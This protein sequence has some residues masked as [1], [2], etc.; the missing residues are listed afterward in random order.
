[1][2][3][4]V[5]KESNGRVQEQFFP[6]SAL[7][8]ETP[9]MAQVRGGALAFQILSPSTV[10]GVVPAANICNLG[11]A[12]RT[13]AEGTHV[14]DGPLGGYLQSEA[15][16]KGLHWMRTIW[17]SGMFQLTSG[18]HPIKS[19]DDLRGFKVRV[20]EARIVVDLFRGLGA[21]PTPMGFNEI[22]TA[23]QTKVVDGTSTPLVTI[24]TGRFYEVQKYIS[25]TNHAWSGLCLISNNDLWKSLPPDIATLIE[26]NNTRYATLER[27]DTAA[28]NASLADKLGRQG[29]TV[30]AIADQTPFRARLKPYFD[31]W[32]AAF[33]PSAGG[34][35]ESSLG[36]KLT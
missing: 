21:N 1:M 4:A 27:R 24:E 2:W 30:N 14:L 33:G 35:L 16:A 23:L 31:T 32:A 13:A 20:S 34:M 25:L 6:E 5:E 19:P 22:Y 17:D 28:L 15:A 8:G 3:N 26:R 10:S 29:V 9:M 11:Y 7:G 12:F 36:R 18:T